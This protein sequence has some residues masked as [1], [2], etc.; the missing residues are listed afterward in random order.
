MKRC[1]IISLALLMILSACQKSKVATL[2]GIIENPDNT[3]L[4]LLDYKITRTPDTIQLINGRFNKIIP[5]RNPGF[6]YIKYGKFKKLLF[7][8]PGYSIYISFNT[9]KVDSTIKLEGN[10]A[11]ENNILDSVN[12]GS[13]K[14][15]YDLAAAKPQEAV[16]KFV[17]SSF[18]AYE[19][20]LEKLTGSQKI[21]T[22]FVKFE[23]KSL[24]Y[25]AASAKTEIGL[26]KDI[27]D[28]DYY[29]YLKSLE[30]ENDHYLHIPSYRDF[31][32][33]YIDLKAKELSAGIKSN[34]P[35]VTLDNLNETLKALEMLKNRKIREYLA[36]Y[37]INWRLKYYGK[38]IFI[39]YKDFIAKNITD[40]VYAR[41]LQKNYAMKLL[42]APG[43]PAPG[44]T[45]VDI[46]NNEVSLKDFLG[47]TVYMD[48]WATW[49][50]PC[51]KE[52]PKYIKLQSDY[53]GKNIAFV[54][55][56]LDDDRSS[57]EKVVKE[58]KSEGISLIA[59]SGRDSKVSKAYQISGI[60]TFVLIDK[61]G[62]IISSQAP[63]PSSNE[64]RK[65]LDSLLKAK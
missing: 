50:G 13:E 65:T 35:H 52:L 40:S 53:K 37:E 6:K 22:L 44:F 61:A 43:Q 4:L 38:D 16:L 25:E 3:P 19:N 56:S 31:L 14:F 9:A 49:C 29:S 45:C 27:N 33:N 48:F 10:G 17:D 8:A 47:K 23:R 60:P 24:E 20:Y 34:N 5:L 46:N 26:D 54:S 11:L 32:I 39:M 58:N 42:L 7:L 15:D 57:W 41:E 36:F 64:I 18:T 51:R 1:F 55:I 63:R 12:K 30:I 28:K 21:D 62:K 59:E 2:S